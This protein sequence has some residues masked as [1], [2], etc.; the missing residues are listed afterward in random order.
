MMGTGDADRQASENLGVAG[1]PYVETLH[2]GSQL[3]PV[4]CTASPA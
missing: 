3:R 2:L 4:S 1:T